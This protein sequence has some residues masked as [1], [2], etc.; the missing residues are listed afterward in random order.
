MLYLG[1]G[2]RELIERTRG[3]ILYY[4]FFHLNVLYNIIKL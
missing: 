3:I 1:S 4:F 2:T